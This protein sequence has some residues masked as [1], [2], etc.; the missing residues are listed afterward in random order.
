VVISFDE[1]F[2]E[3]VVNEE[4]NHCNKEIDEANIISEYPP[5]FIRYFFI[6]I[7]FTPIIS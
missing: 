3:D 1:N 5:V 4:Y 7:N 2:F 6:M